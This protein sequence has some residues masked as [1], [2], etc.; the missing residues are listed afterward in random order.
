MYT[1]GYLLGA[2]RAKLD[3]DENDS[4]Y[5]RFSKNFAYYANEVITQVCS[6]I[7]PKHCFATITVTDNMLLEPTDLRKAHNDYAGDKNFIAFGDDV[8]TITIDGETRP[9]SDLDFRYYGYSSCIFYTPGTYV[10]S[11]NAR[12]VDFTEVEVDDE[13][14]VPADILD[15]IPSYVVSQCY[16]VDDEYKSSVFRNEYEMSLARID[17][18]DYKNTKTFTIGGDW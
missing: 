7:K 5:G 17:D 6:T 11:Y 3:I 14:D 12:W 15:C 2:I 10:I 8:N 4:Y 9:A 18:T 1:W 13:L 16:K